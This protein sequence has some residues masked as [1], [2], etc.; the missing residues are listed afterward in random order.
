M[1]RRARPIPCVPISEWRPGKFVDLRDAKAIAIDVETYDPHLTDKGPGWARHAGHLVGVSIGT[2][3]G[4]RGYFPMRHT[5]GSEQ[6]L[7]TDHVLAWLREQLAGNQPKIGANLL[8]DVGWLREEGVR[9]GG[10]LLDVQFAEALLTESGSTALE[11]LGT[12]Y[13]GEGK[14]SP[15][16]YAWCAKAYGGEINGSQRANI[17]RAPPSLVGPYA[18]SDVDLPLRV[19]EHQW[20]A[21][22]AQNLLD[23]FDLECRLIPLLI[24]MRMRG[25]AVN[26][27][28]AEQLRDKLL[29]R[30]RAAQ[31]ELEALAGMSVE[32]NAAASL[33]KAFE[34]AGIAYPRTEKTD[35][36][37]FVKTFLAA[38][39]HP[40]AAKVLEV[41]RLEKLRSTF[42]E[43]Y[44][45]ADHVSGRLHGQF[46]PLRKSGGDDDGGT[47]SGRL[48]SSAPNLQNLP[49]RDEELAPL[50]RGLFVP[51]RG[52]VGWWSADYSQ[53]EYRIF[54]HFAVGAGSDGVRRQFCEDPRTD[55]HEWTLDLVAPIAGWDVSTKALRKHWRKPIK[56]INFGLLYGMGRAKLA[57][58]L[59][60]D[61]AAAADLFDAYHKGV[62]F[63][64]A[65]MRKY[66]D[67]ATKF[68]AV[69][70]IL[71]R[72]SRFELWEP[73]W[74]ALS[75]EE[76]AFIN[77]SPEGGTPLPLKR[78][79][80]VYGQVRLAKTHKALNR[81][82]QGSA[83]D[84]MKAAMV[85]AWEDGIFAV[86]G[87]PCLTVHDEL[88]FSDSG[89]ADD[90]FRELVH[91]METVIPLRV[92][93]R[94]EVSK[95]P[96]WGHCKAA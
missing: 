75:S 71:G 44:V 29:A 12:K 57:R 76:V 77:S 46:H 81:L 3:D 21:L 40:I 91:V 83:A 64:Q 92:P 54:A 33:A 43:S 20:P 6:N 87:V 70:T 66:S 13:L 18:Q 69:D 15:A 61:D 23:V 11:A 73:D 78:A 32:V 36:P 79:V 10:T 22:A 72:K 31:S 65:T 37:S 4:F 49:S 59:G 25:V 19:L 41:R 38:C 27:P 34:S 30:E 90:A 8:Y 62:P 53:I 35:A 93:V 74:R 96:D 51:D 52:H 67:H 85:R 39:D 1:M 88:D 16:L 95:G 86:T 60:L 58:S 2:D 45:L 5:V 94:A 56:N 7:D 82:L 84:L 68:W 24:E 42:V 28:R 89:T 50:V 80:E 63:A 26:I 48:S 17:Y 55:F 47:R 9:V 14:E